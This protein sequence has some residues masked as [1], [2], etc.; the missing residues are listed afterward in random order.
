MIFYT[1]DTHFGHANIIKYCSRPFADTEEMDAALIERWNAVV[2][3]TDDVFV[4]GDV[5]LGNFKAGIEKVKQLKGNKFLIP[6]N[7]DRIFSGEGRKALPYFPV[8]EEAGFHILSEYTT[9]PVGAHMVLASHFP[10]AG[11]SQDKDRY[12]D[13]RPVNEGEW[14]LHGHV[15]EK[16]KINASRA[17]GKMI[18]VGVDVWGFKPVSE[19]EIL[20]IMDTVRV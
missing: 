4:L 3:D 5:I 13:R 11:D 1:A 7:H 16:W 20:A 19:D 14:L 9:L 6:G 8:Y 2:Q 18:N 12:V 17:N 15:H 10:Y